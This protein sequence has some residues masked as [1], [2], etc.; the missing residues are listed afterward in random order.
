[1]ALS[2]LGGML[3]G[4]AQRAGITRNL[5]ITE[6][7]RAAQSALRAQFGDEYSKFAEPRSVRRDGSLTIACRSPAVA[8]T[9]RLQEAAILEHIRREVSA[10]T[11]VRLFLIPR[12]S[13]DITSP[14]DIASA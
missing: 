4:A 7:L 5:A 13:A 3:R 1:M 2:S 12:S 8:Q 14:E 11:I 6:V 9:I 10:M